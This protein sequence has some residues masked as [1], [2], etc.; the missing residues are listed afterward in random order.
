MN[1]KN[2]FGILIILSALLSSAGCNSNTN[3][4]ISSIPSHASVT[5]NSK[6]Q[7]FSTT[8]LVTQSDFSPSWDIG[9]NYCI[10]AKG[11]VQF[12]KRDLKPFGEVGQPYISRVYSMGGS[13]W[14]KNNDN[15]IS[16]RFPEKKHFFLVGRGL[17]VKNLRVFLGRDINKEYALILQEG[18]YNVYSNDWIADIKS[19]EGICY[20][21]E[22]TKHSKIVSEPELDISIIAKQW[23][24]VVITDSNLKSHDLIHSKIRNFTGER[25]T[26]SLIGANDDPSE[27]IIRIKKKK[28]WARKITLRI[29][30]SYTLLGN[31]NF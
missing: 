16:V 8:T 28:G 11:R 12:R 21:F 20:D 26:I 22:Q 2:L 5:V 1:Y 23:K 9:L 14:I 15:E 25:F 18:E 6:P 29:T 27:I 4:W 13:A 24:S 19:S 31:C 10:S 17:K 7:E 3:V 30:A